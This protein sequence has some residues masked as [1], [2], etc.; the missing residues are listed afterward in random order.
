MVH[1]LVRELLQS[2]RTLAVA[3]SLTGGALAAKV[4]DTA[5]AS[6]A[7]LGGI[8][9][10]SAQAKRLLLGVPADLIELRGTVDP[11]VALQMAIGVQEVFGS[12]VALAT[13]GVAGPGPSEQKPEGTVFIAAVLGEQ[14]MGRRFR[15]E[16]G[17]A[18]IREQTVEAALD[19][20]L[21]RLAGDE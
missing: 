8:V 14:T 4:V 1:N 20:A 11:D 21:A 10:Y 15:F 18:A 19:L 12:D 13:T 2:R 17:R 7:F 3:E 9:A 6:G 5:G 16:G